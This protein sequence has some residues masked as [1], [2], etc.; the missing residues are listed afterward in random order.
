M[1]ASVSMKRPVQRSAVEPQA[2]SF[3]GLSLYAPPNA[4][5]LLKHAALNPFSW[6]DAAPAAATSARASFLA[7]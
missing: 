5:L 6:T 2:R 3:A 4:S 7:V 1:L